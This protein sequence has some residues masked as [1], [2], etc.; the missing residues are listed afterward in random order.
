[1]RDWQDR[2][3]ADGAM[4]VSDGVIANAAPD[5]SALADCEALGK[6]LA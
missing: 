6:A 3:A 2:V 5:G 1:M 4:L